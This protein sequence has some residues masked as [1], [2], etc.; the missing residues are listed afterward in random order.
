MRLEHIAG[1]TSAHVVDDIHIELL[2]VTTGG[3]REGDTCSATGDHVP[4]DSCRQRRLA[5]VLG[6]DMYLAAAT[7]QRAS[8][9]P[10]P[11]AHA[12]ALRIEL[13]SHDANAHVLKLRGSL[14]RSLVD[15]LCVSPSELG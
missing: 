3:F 1:P 8:K 14:V 6:N 4:H 2:D 13:K 10:T 12:A 7:R 15:Q 5:D 11:I 9:L